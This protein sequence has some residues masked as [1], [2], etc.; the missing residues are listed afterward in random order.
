MH[1]PFLQKCRAVIYGIILMEET[2]KNEHN[3]MNLLLV[4]VRHKLEALNDIKIWDMGY[5]G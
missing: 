2:T 5:W 1:V 4:G 3:D